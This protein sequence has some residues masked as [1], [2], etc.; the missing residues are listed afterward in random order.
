MAA[1]LP[2][3]FIP[4]LLCT[5][6]IYE[7]QALALGSDRTVLF[8]DHAA[9][10]TMSGTAKAVLAAAPAKFALVG[11]SMGGYAAF[12]IMRQA[13]DRVGALVLLSTSAKPDA[14]EKSAARRDQV[15]TAQDKGVRAVSDALYPKLVHPARAEDAPLYAVFDAMAKTTGADG[16]ARQIE[17]II[18]RA[19][20]RPLL[21]QIHVPT[22]VV[23]GAD[24]ELIPPDHSAEIADG[25]KGARFEKIPHCAHMGM[26]ELPETYTTLLRDFLG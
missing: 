21:A 22:L 4:G 5:G 17:A 26:I 8:A 2:L 14:P 13:P 19:D 16:F 11:T 23:A 15:K 6:R 24:D 7:H 1:P 9:H 10:D 20:S 3:V 25:I 18:G 12:E